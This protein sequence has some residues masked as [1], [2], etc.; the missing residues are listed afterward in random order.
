HPAELAGDQHSHAAIAIIVADRRRTDIFPL[1]GVF[2][3]RGKLANFGENPFQCLG[4]MVA[5]AEE[6]GISGRA[7]SVLG[8]ETEE[9]SSF[10]NQ[11]IR[12]V[13]LSQACKETT[14]GELLEQ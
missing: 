3:F 6:I 5:K 7:V 2:L 14:E 13:T 1:E 8:E 4:V 10:E 11:A 9:L 12:V